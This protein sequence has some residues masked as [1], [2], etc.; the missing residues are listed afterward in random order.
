MSIINIHVISIEKPSLN[1]YNTS[2]QKKTD[3]Q[4]KIN[5]RLFTPFGL[6]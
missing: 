5:N 3:S 1:K 4:L 6:Y 2:I